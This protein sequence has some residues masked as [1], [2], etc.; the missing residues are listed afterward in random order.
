V[1]DEQ[2]VRDSVTR[3]LSENGCITESASNASEA[4]AKLQAQ[5]FDLVV[6]DFLM[7]GMNGRQLAWAIKGIN[8]GM[9]I[10]LLTGFFPA[11]PIEEIDCVLLKPFTREQ[12]WT[13]M[14]EVFM[15]VTSRSKAA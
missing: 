12:L 3:M 10:I 7:R 15:R 11:G 13:A 4:L 14:G 5:P 9:P 2:A 1:D 6:T 8:P